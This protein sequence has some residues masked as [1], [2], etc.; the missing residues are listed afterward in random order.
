MPAT[1]D[2]LAVAERVDVDLDRVGQIAVEQQRILAEHRVDLAG[3]VVGIAR[4][5]VGRHQARQHAEQIV[6]E[7]G[8]VVDDRH[9]PAAEHVG[10]A[11]DQRQAEVG[12]RRAAPARPNRRCRS[13]AASRPSLS[14]SR[15][16]RSR[17]SARSIEFDRGAEDRRARLLDGVRELQRR[18]AA[19]LDDH[20]LQRPV[21]PLLVE[22]GEH[23]LLRS[24][25]R[26]RGGPRCRSR[27][28]PSP[29][30]S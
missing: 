14:R 24:A 19:E 7:R 13:S 11:H 3:L 20:A 9:R 15:L 29:D 6:V 21:L 23:V 25:A 17:S 30:C 5:D 1:N 26:N 16:N 22:D 8:L 18:L 27:S 10:G 4:L 2:G 28:T 12:R